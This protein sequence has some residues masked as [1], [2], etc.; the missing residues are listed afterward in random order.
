MG[1][2]GSGVTVQNYTEYNILSLDICEREHKST[3]RSVIN[4]V[5]D[6]VSS[7]EK[8]LKIKCTWCH[9]KVCE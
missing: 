4:E 2:S 3:R 5:T 7:C 9:L 1:Y 6:L 8:L